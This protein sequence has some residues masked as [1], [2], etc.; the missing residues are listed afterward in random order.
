MSSGELGDPKKQ[1]NLEQLMEFQG[2][3]EVSLT[4]SP[5][6]IPLKIKQNST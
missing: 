3:Q 6:Q 2:Q 1:L 4:K 5:F